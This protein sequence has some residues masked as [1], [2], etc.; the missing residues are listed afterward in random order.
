MRDDK[1]FKEL[2]PLDEIARESQ[3]IKIET[4]KRRYGKFVTIVSGFDS[5][6][7]DIKEL[8]KTLKKKTATGGTVKD[9]KIELQG[10]QRERVKKVLEE[11][12]FKVEVEK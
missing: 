4:D 10:D 1:I 2:T 11:L 12:G 7:E 8:A 3:I 9:E 5:H 6:T